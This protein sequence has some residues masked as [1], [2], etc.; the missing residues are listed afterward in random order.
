[1]VDAVAARKIIIRC[2]ADLDRVKQYLEH[3]SSYG[4]KTPSAASF[5]D[6]DYESHENNEP[7]VC[8]E[9]PTDDGEPL[10]FVWK[11]DVSILTTTG[12]TKFTIFF[13]CSGRKWQ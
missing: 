6:D 1:M 10:N 3:D 4:R 9:C 2:L 13:Y 12:I 5:V 11:D 7:C 8:C